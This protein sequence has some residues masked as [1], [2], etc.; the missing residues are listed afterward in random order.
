MDALLDS[1]RFKV[2]ATL[3][4][5]VVTLGIC[6]FMAHRAVTYQR[7][8]RGAAM[9]A[10]GDSAR[11]FPYLVRSARAGLLGRLNASPLLDLGE[12]STRAL[13]DPKSLRFQKGI[14]PALAARLAFV[15][16][17]GALV[18][19]PTSSTALA[20]L[21]DLFRK[22]GNL[23]LVGPPD[24]APT[25]TDV[26][27]RSGRPAR[28]DRLVEAAYL[29]AIEMEPANYFWYGYL[30]D[31]FQ[32]RGRRQEALPLY[33][34]AIELMPD[35][36]WHY[37]LGASG[38]LS[39][40]MFEVARRGLERALLT[41]RVMRP[42]RIESSFG[43]LYERQRDYEGAL[44]HYRRAIEIAP[45]PS[46]YLNQ[47]AI[48]FEFQGRRAEA[49]DYFRRALARGTL[50]D[51][52]A[53]VALTHLGRI[54]IDRG[55]LRE[56]AGILVQARNRQPASYAIRVDLGRAWKGLGELDKAEN[57]YRQ[58]LALDPSQRQAY[59]LLIEMYRATG[60]IARA[61]PL[62]RRLLEMYPEDPKLKVLLD[63]LYK[64]MGTSPG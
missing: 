59:S 51:R 58:A 29:K 5:G 25:L 43:F 33:E 53:L 38:P 37:Y 62:A 12:A 60:D 61:I 34:K 45:D 35:L 6:A 46:Q 20:G 17:A 50:G 11:A 8:L 15:S 28:V 14:T 57:E 2:L 30:A 31:F 26:L 10:A 52:Q 44:L 41:N 4:V 64:E 48:V 49:A 13:D 18:R 3:L 47:A 16:Y 22:V 54:L 1:R 55:E 27:E 19:R 63:D 23:D 42:E 21:A 7:A 24:P 39:A 40:E 36:S 56:A 9:H 32:E